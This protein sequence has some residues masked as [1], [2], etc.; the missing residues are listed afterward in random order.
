MSLKGKLGMLMAM[1]LMFSEQGKVATSQYEPKQPKRKLTP[2]EVEAEIKERIRKFNNELAQENERLS[3]EFGW[4]FYYVNDK[5]NVCASN[6]KNAIKRFNY[7]LKSNYLL[8]EYLVKS[9]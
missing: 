1:G 3:Y 8:L 6:R 7:L 5:W 4:D 9:I 2:E